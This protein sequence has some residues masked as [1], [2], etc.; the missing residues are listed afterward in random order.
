MV[1][2]QVNSEGKEGEEEEEKKSFREVKKEKEVEEEQEGVSGKGRRRGGGGGQTVS[3]RGSKIR[4]RGKKDAGKEEK[5]TEEVGQEIE[6]LE[7]AG[8]AD[9]DGTPVAPDPVHQMPSGVQREG[10][11]TLS[12]APPP[13]QRY[14][15]GPGAC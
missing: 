10:P 5:L 9:G 6:M 14:S 4:G 7:A 8:A 1:V 11:H 2:Y 15:G 13:D 3:R 12:W